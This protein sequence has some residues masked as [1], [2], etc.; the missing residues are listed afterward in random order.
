MAYELEKIEVEGWRVVFDLEEWPQNPRDWDNVGVFIT[1]QGHYISP[2]KNEFYTP[3]DFLQWW[4][5]N[6]EGGVMLPVFFIDHSSIGYSTRDYLNSWDSGQVGFIYATAEKI[7]AEKLL[8]EKVQGY[9][10]NEVEA[11]SAYSNGDVFG[12][13]VQKLKPVCSCGEC[14]EWETV[15]SV[16]GQ[17]EP[18]ELMDMELP[19]EAPAALLEALKKS[20]YVK[21]LVA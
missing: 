1:W 18:V 12:Y 9:L 21:A 5:I 6:G 8:L 3:D 13:R 20:N 7:E 15:E 10:T 14:K 2:D 4:S 19:E 16:G 11:Y 17:F